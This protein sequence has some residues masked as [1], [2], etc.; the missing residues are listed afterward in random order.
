MNQ[1][2]RLTYLEVLKHKND[3]KAVRDE[4]MVEISLVRKGFAYF[5][6]T[7]SP[8]LHTKARIVPPVLL[9]PRIG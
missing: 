4:N 1:V 6:I 9:V 2:A 8:K 3:V 7:L 5:S